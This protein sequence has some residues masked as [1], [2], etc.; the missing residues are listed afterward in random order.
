MHVMKKILALL[1][2]VL[3]VVACSKDID[4][5]V[6]M[7]AG[8]G[9]IRFAVASQS[10][11]TA[12]DNVVIKIYKVDGA[13]E[14][15][16]RRYDS[17]N[18]V[19]DYLA[20]LAGSYVAKVQVGEKHAVS[21][22]SKYYYGESTFEVKPSEVAAVTVDCKLQS[23]IVT[24][25]Y[26]A[27]V[28]ATLSEGYF[29]TVAI[30][31]S[32]DK[33][34][35]ATGDVLS[36]TYNDSKD[37]YVIMPEG[38]TSLY[39]HFEGTHPVEG[40]IIKE[41]LIENIKPA[42]RYTITLKYS[43]DAPG[44]LVFEATVDESVEEF[45][46]TIIFSPDPTV[47]GEGF[48]IAS[49]QLSTAASRTYNVTSLASISAITLNASGVEYDLLQNA[50]AGITVEKLDEVTYKVIVAEAF[51]TL[52]AG[53]EQ[54]LTFHVEDVD[55]GKL[56][57]DVNYLVQGI[58][59]LSTSDYD[60]WF[61]N[62]TFTATVLNEAAS[63][64]KVAY[65]ADGVAWT[66]VDAVVGA[67]GTYTAAGAN[68]AAEQNYSYKLIVDGVEAGKTLTHQTAAGAQIP[69]G[70]MES[71]SNETTPSGLWSSG[72]NSFTTLLKQS[73]DA[74]GGS[75]SANLTARSAVGKF[76][77][78]NLFTGS[79]E[80]SMSTMSGKVTFGKDFRYTARPRSVT[81]WMK[82]N[83]GN[84]THGNKTSGTDPYSAMVLI[85]DGTVY[86][87][88]TTDESTFLTKDNL[89]DK[90]G[91]IAYAFLSDTDS[92]GDWVQKTLE[93]TYV[94]NWQSMTPKKISVSFSTSA[95]GDYFCGST[96]SWMYVDDIVLNY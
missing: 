53:G 52:V 73:N 69:N 30:A 21:F 38:Q 51:F 50:P 34:A 77:A 46:D 39:W 55:G 76:A 63:S 61:G 3:A 36:L 78:G 71:W 82:N 19:P 42:A 57:K 32:Y 33:Q 88:D 74:H 45:E 56:T 26:D 75:S 58:M 18:D 14:A 7:A 66:E 89:K 93:L 25:K 60:L 84:I 48:D 13:E 40:D 80:L 9:A 44:N 2:M 5:S 95:Y 70:D 17:V 68:F 47:I 79:F 81:F 49:Q 1:S 41:G 16:I 35:I 29:T 91:M 62:V 83:Q 31:E 96:E 86:T 37:G 90:P 6:E 65:S 4:A 67:D 11:I 43:K 28:A 8:E 72:N 24:V 85:T 27:T 64:V 15:L 94:D 87:V 20:L 59:P 22:D 54:V 23:T 10:D 92:N 12:D